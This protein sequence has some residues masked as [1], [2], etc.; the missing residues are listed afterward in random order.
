MVE[1]KIVKKIRFGDSTNTVVWK[2]IQIWIL[3]CWCFLTVGIL[4]G[5][6]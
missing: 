3:T 1:K 2:K 4:L 6:W 5:S